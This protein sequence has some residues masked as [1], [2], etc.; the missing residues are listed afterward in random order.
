MR[1][2]Q[3]PREVGGSSGSGGRAGQ[4]T[5]RLAPVPSVELATKLL[6]R[7]QK[8][9]PDLLGR[10]CREGRS[11]D[12]VIEREV[13]PVD[14]SGE[15]GKSEQRDRLTV[16]EGSPGMFTVTG[17]DDARGHLRNAEGGLGPVERVAIGEEGDRTVRRPPT[18]GLPVSSNVRSGGS[19]TTSSRSAASSGCSRA[20]R[21]R[22]TPAVRSRNGTARA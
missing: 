17:H 1:S 18:S 21:A 16:G 19:M 12:G 10:K 14:A 11:S 2:S 6:E 13:A 22:R 4:A 5:L 7:P 15:V 8:R 9:S 3:A 20:T